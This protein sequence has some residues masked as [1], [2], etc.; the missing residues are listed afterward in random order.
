MMLF[1]SRER[2]TS[3]CK[4]IIGGGSFLSRVAGGD[5]PR[6]GLSYPVQHD[7]LPH[8]NFTNSLRIGHFPFYIRLWTLSGLVCSRIRHFLIDAQALDISGACLFYPLYAGSGFTL[9]PIP[10]PDMLSTAAR[11]VSSDVKQGI[12]ASVAALRMS[13]PS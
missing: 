4:K 12:L 10:D 5:F 2:A 9:Y 13:K 11:A 8:P 3:P 6:Y 1:L 7:S